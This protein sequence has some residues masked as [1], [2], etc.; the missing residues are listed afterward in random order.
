MLKK[1]F[2]LISNYPY[3]KDIAVT[4]QYQEQKMTQKCPNS[5]KTLWD[6]HI[7]HCHENYHKMRN[8]PKYDRESIHELKC[9]VCYCDSCQKSHFV[10]KMTLVHQK[11]WK[12]VKKWSN[13]K[14]KDT[15][16][17]KTFLGWVMKVTLFLPFGD[18][19]TVKSLSKH[20]KLWD[21]RGARDW[22]QM[23]WDQVSRGHLRHIYLHFN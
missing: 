6:C 12:M 18:I 10:E 17:N 22:D 7:C 5:S 21:C 20:I 8:S 13:S 16:I 19:L 1:W 11:C 2:K 3:S 23:R 15:F 4:I 9:Q 14:N